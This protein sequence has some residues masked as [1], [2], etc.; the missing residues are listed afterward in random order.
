M[1]NIYPAIVIPAYNRASTLKRLLDSL[2]RANFPAGVDVP[3]IISIDPENGAPNPDVLN[4]AKSFVWAHGRKEVKIHE[5]HL[6]ML[7]NFYYCGGLTKIYPAIIYLEDDLFLS[8]AFYEFARKAHEFYQDD[9][10][11]AGVSLYAYHFN[12]YHHFP[13][14]PI[15][16]GADVYFAQIMSILGQSWTEAQWSQFLQ[17]DQTRASETDFVEKELHDIWGT[18]AEDEYFPLQMKYL[19]STNRYYVF[20]RV[21]LTTGFGDRGVHFDSATSYFQVPLQG[22]QS[23]FRFRAFENANAVYD[24][25]MELSPERFERLVPAL[26]GMSFDVDLNAT[27]KPHHFKA[28]Y[29]LTTRACAESRQTFALSMFPAEA[30]VLNQIAGL[31]ITFAPRS[32]VKWGRRS[33]LQARFRLHEYYQRGLTGW[34]KTFKQLFWNLFRWLA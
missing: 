2:S 33:D 12:G 30:N 21:S 6:G 9:V 24:S 8:P 18:F 25:F 31:G 3:L 19:A 32:A 1:N 27:K 15:E 23:I 16:D 11:I 14:T 5:A 28:E 17:W 4:L 34:I 26:R 22:N 29:V 13:F 20:P 10:R 7:K